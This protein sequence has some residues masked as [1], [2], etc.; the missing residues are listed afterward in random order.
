MARMQ[1]TANPVSVPKTVKEAILG[2]VACSNPEI[3]CRAVQRHIPE[4]DSLNAPREYTQ[5]HSK[6]SSSQVLPCEAEEQK[7]IKERPCGTTKVSVTSDERS[8]AG[9]E[10]GSVDPAHFLHHPH[11]RRMCQSKCTRTPSTAKAEGSG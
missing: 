8:F 9:E 3:L 4:T 11:Q 2:T 1:C 6:P 7:H 5:S 10:R